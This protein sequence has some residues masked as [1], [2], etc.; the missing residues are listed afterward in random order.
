MKP[1]NCGEMVSGAKCTGDH[2]KMLHGSGNVY[3]AALSAGGVGQMSDVFACVKED[4]DTVYYLQDIPVAKSKVM[5][6]TLW[7]RGSNRVLIREDF[8]P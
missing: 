2:S 5:A 8:A 7:D 4:E 3:C 1:N 6:R